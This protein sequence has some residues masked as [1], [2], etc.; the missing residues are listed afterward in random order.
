MYEKVK[1]L[2]RY[3]KKHNDEARELFLKYE[4]CETIDE[5]VFNIRNNIGTKPL[6]IYPNCNEKKS[7]SKYNKKG[8]ADGCR[9]HA[10]K[11]TFLKKY[12]VE[13]PFQNEAIKSKIK[14]TNLKRYGVENVAQN[15]DIKQKIIDTTYERYGVT[16]ALKSNI[17]K[18]KIKDTI[19]K[20]YGHD[21]ISKSEIIKYKKQQTSLKKYG[22]CHPLQN[23]KIKSKLKFT[24]LKKY[25][26]ENFNNRHK[27]K[28]TLIKQYGVDSIGKIKNKDFWINVDYDILEKELQEYSVTYLAQK[29]NVAFTTIYDIVHE[30]GFE[31]SSYYIGEQFIIDFIDGVVEYKRNDR[32]VLKGKE[33]DIYI[34]KNKVAIEIN[35]NYWHSNK[36]GKDINYHLSKTIQ[37]EN[38]GISLIHIFEDEI[39]TNENHLRSLIHRFINDDYYDCFDIVDIDDINEYECL[40]KH[41]FNYYAEFKGIVYDNDMVGLINYK[42]DGNS[43]IIYNF[44]ECGTMNIDIEKLILLLEEHIKKVY[45]YH[46]RRFLDLRYLDKGFTIIERNSPNEWFLSND[47]MV[48]ELTNNKKTQNIIYDV[49]TVKMVKEL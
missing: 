20:K 36:C 14:E 7:F 2:K 3:L 49:G 9:K 8:Y 32:K 28:Q 40:T 41:M 18:E 19:L 47:Y 44:Y 25:G 4:W 38:Q 39:K 35:G 30:K 45:I 17:I 37:C 15:E 12:G 16:N 29:Y 43:I 23:E 46:D 10:K 6:C 1:Q 21:N 24:K 11:V 13:N 48:R 27:A 31:T 42:I 33:L 22:V 34:P 26:D 5:L